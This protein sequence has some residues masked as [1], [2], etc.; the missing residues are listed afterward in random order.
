[1]I[2]NKRPLF[3]AGVCGAALGVAL[4]CRPYTTAW[5]CVPLG[6]AAIVKRKELS[7][8]HILIG[9]VPILVA[10]VTFLA[11]NYATTWHPLLFGYIAMHGEDHY[12]GFHPAPWSDQPTP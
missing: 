10:C 7:P 6:I 4:L 12:P 1:M 5:I 8:R 11:Y 2:K 9:M 3:S